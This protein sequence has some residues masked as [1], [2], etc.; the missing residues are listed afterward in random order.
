MNEIYKRTECITASILAK[1]DISSNYIV[2]L[3]TVLNNNT[4]SK[5]TLVNG[6]IKIGAGVEIVEVTGNLMV[7]NITGSG[8]YVWGRIAKFKET[9]A[10]VEWVDTISSSISFMTNV[11]LAHLSTPCPS[12]ILN[13]QEGDLIGFVADKSGFND[14]VPY[15]RALKDATWLQVRILK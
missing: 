11:S 2:N 12:R 6:K 7:D 15:L 9:D 3:N 14:V 4:D 8:G 13:V 1:Q 10:G 5:L